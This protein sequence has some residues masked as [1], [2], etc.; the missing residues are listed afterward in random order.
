MPVTTIPII[1]VIIII[2][3]VTILGLETDQAF[4]HPV[5]VGMCNF[6]SKFRL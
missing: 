1:I 6:S 5:K 2:F 3:F 4:A